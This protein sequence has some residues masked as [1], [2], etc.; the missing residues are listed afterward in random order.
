M[1]RRPTMRRTGPPTCEGCGARI[2]FV[3][4]VATGKRVPCDPMPVADGNVCARQ[5]GNQ[6]HGYVISED[7]APQP[8]MLRYAAH[9]GTCPDR[10]DTRKPTPPTPPTLFD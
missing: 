1:P 7:R 4:M 5:I 2:V 3:K 8:N 6:L 10:Q 9:F